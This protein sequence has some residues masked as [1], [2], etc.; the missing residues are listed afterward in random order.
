MVSEKNTQELPEDLAY[1]RGSGEVAAR[2]DDLVGRLAVVAVVGVVESEG[3]EEGHGKGAPVLCQLV[4][5]LLERGGEGSR[6]RRRRWSVPRGRGYRYHALV[7]VRGARRAGA[8]RVASVPHGGK[9]A[10]GSSST[11]TGTG[12]GAKETEPLE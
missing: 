9:G 5:V 10:R 2:A 11:G 3:R 1:L 6:R 4:E 8:R 12:A 7:A